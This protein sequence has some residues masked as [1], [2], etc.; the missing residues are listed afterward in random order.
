MSLPVPLLDDRRFQDIVDEAKRLIPR[1]CPGWTDHN[2]SDPGVTLIELFAWMTEMILY[3]VNQIPDLHYTKFL[4]LMGI[5]LFPASSARSDVA[6]WLSAPQ[7]EAVRLHPN[8]Q[9]GTVRTEQEESIVFLTDNEL[10][11]VV[12]TLRA[13]LTGTSDGR[14]EDHWD[15]LRRPSSEVTC[16]PSTSAGDAIYFGFEHSLANNIIRL[17]VKA[18]I[19]GVGIVP[20]NPPW[21]WEVWS[22][23]EW[24]PAQVHEDS[25]GGF[26]QDGSITLFVPRRHESLIIGPAR[27]HWVRCVMT[28]PIGDQEPYRSS[29]TV[30]KLDVVSLGGTM[31]AHHAQLVPRERIGRGEGVPGQSFTVRRTPV[32]PRRDDET[33]VIVT[34]G[35]EEPWTEVRDFTAS[36]E[37]DRHFTW[38][39][40]AGVVSFG[41]LIH[42]PDGSRKQFGAIPPIGADIYVTGY[43]FGGG[44]AG[45][46]GAKTLTALKTSIPFVAA[47]ENLTPAHGGVDA[48]TIENAKLRGPMTIRTGQRAVTVNDFERLTLEASSEVARSRCLPPLEPGGPVRVLV[49]PRVNIPPDQ[50]ALDDLALSDPLVEGVSSYLDERRILTTPVEIDTPFYQGITV[51]AQ[52]RGTPG[53]GP[54]LLR[55]RLLTELYR[56]INPLIGGP[57]GTGWPFGR[58]L[59]VGEI[60][61][62]LSGMNGVTL[63]EEVLI[64]LADLR[65]RERREARQ[66]ARLADNAVFA[67]FQHQIRVR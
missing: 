64:Y 61:A 5:Q 9:V 58:E 4:E 38:D 27:A 22:G 34:T 32:L 28:D 31:S 24:I 53:L 16:F 63:V 41:P 47:V 48:E 60:F 37:S 15:D 43:R 21:S 67:S 30:S 46:V 23:D 25:S 8:T 42:Y 62:L 45:N 11:I 13:C 18:R 35:G 36:G 7:P 54:E 1:Y 10:V 56:Y 6:F 65:T 49:I 26:N 33:V 12:P 59:N 29:P 57:G 66:R 51:I 44:L 40:T 17:D 14:Y 3:R 39:S 2:L 52:V 20:T 50:L 55:D 19:E